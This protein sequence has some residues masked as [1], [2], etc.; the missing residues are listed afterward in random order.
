MS[1]ESVLVVPDARIR[2]DA[3]EL[4]Q[5]GHGAATARRPQQI[6]T[7]ISQYSTA[8]VK[9]FSLGRSGKL[10]PAGHREHDQALGEGEIVAT[11]GSPDASFFCAPV[12]F[13]ANRCEKSGSAKSPTWQAF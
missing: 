2:Y 8:L 7:T 12:P 3:C 1:A 11:N 6:A 13:R 9:Y 4:V 5:Q 10:L